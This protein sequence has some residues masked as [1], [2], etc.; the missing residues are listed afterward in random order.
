MRFA[1]VFVRSFVFVLFVAVLRDK[2]V[3]QIVLGLMPFLDNFAHI[4]GLVM[5]FFIGLGL[6][7]QKR[8]DGTG[9][10]LD[11]KCYQVRTD[12]ELKHAS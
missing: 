8:E 10:A 7:V 1:L 11:K 6:L 12:R 2:T 9:E 3:L 5:G 4:G